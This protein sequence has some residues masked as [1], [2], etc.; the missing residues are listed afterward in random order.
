MTERE[1]FREAG[2]RTLVA[3]GPRLRTAP[4][5][6]PRMICAAMNA[7][8]APSQIVFAGERSSA[9][10]HALTRAAHRRFLPNYVLLHGGNGE[11]PAGGLCLPELHMPVARDY[12]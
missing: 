6:T 10:F 8:G 9:P 7:T 5:A 11:W 2:A 1:D 12:R 3:F 4:H